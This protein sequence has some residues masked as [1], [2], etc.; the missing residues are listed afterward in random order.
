[1]NKAL[2]II[3]AIVVVAAVVIGVVVW[4]G[5]DEEGVGGGGEPVADVTGSVAV[6]AVWTGAEQ[7]SFQA[8]LDGFNEAYPNVTVT[9]TSAGDQL[10]TVLGTAVE[11]GNPPDIAVLPQP[12]LMKEYADRGELQSIDF[13][14]ETIDEHFA[15]DWVKLGTVDDTLYGLIFKGANKS[16]VWYNV[17]VVN[18]A[19]V[20][21]PAT[22]D[23]L[24]QAAEQIGA[25]GVP[26]YSIAGA[27]GWTLTDLFENIYLRTAGPELYDQLT[28][29]EIP[30]TD[31]SVTVALERMADLF[32]DT[33]NIAGGTA[34]AL[35][36][37]FPTSVT[38]VFKE[39]PDAAMVFEGDFVQGVILDASE[40]M[41][42]E[43]FDVFTFPSIEGS[44]PSVM[45]GGDLAVM[46]RDSDASRALIEY[47]ATPEAGEI[48]AARGGFSSP[49]R[50]VDPAVY[51]DDLTRQT[52]T[53]LA[54]AETFRFD[55]S[56]L[57]PSEF[58]GTPGQG[59]WQILQDFLQSPDQIEQTQQRL[60]SAAA[61]AY[62]R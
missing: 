51:P 8:V 62:G 46:F 1:M 7:A 19:G 27:D 5:D 55:L 54:E 45:G 39:S 57:T 49:N 31:P 22:W 34:G 35:Q 11:G 18:G 9:Y 12:G 43:D 2:W 42:G 21:P 33:A 37:D 16:T 61:Q 59:M 13:A 6:M 24:L 29:H 48:W 60:E 50:N 36:T 44:A 20:T 40:A 3:I 17:N 58:G 47:L 30:W 38:Q 32:A 56:D 23:E 25:S 4:T 41:P 15:E 52:A 14:R 53:D 28:A 10:P 26:A